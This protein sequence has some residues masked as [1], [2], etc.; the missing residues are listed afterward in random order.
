VDDA[1]PLGHAIRMS[2]HAKDEVT[3]RF[4]LVEGAELTVRVKSG[5]LAIVIE[6]DGELEVVR[7]TLDQVGPLRGLRRPRD[8]RVERALAAMRAEPSRRFTARSLAKIAGASQS[9]LVRLFARYV[10]TTPRA[11]LAAQRLELARTLVT[12]T[13]E[14]LAEI[15][16]RTG[17]ASEFGLSRAF[18]RHFG[19]A[20]SVLRRTTSVPAPIRCAA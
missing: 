14:G 18:K 11:W 10:G 3:R 7:R 5:E 2:T 16:R 9:T 1:T 15:A 20:P 8:L 13:D 12:E 6:G 19:V 17:Y 4:S